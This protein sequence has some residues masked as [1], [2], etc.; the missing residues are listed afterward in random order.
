MKWKF[1]FL[2]SLFFLL[3]VWA[4]NA[5]LVASYFERDDLSIRDLFSYGL[6]V[7]PIYGFTHIAPSREQ[8]KNNS[9]QL[10]SRVANLVLERKPDSDLLAPLHEIARQKYFDNKLQSAQISYNHYLNAGNPHPKI[11]LSA[12]EK[13]QNEIGEDSRKANIICQAI[14]DELTSALRQS[15]KFVFVKPCSLELLTIESVSR[16]LLR[17]L[18]KLLLPFVEQGRQRFKENLQ[19]SANRESLSLQSSIWINPQTQFPDLQ[20]WCDLGWP[21]ICKWLKQRTYVLEFHFINTQY[22]SFLI[23]GEEK[24]FSTV[25]NDDTQRLLLEASN[26]PV[27]ITLDVQFERDNVAQIDSYRRSG[28]V[29]M[30][31]WP[32]IETMHEL[33]RNLQWSDEWTV[34]ISLTSSERLMQ[35]FKSLMS[36][37]PGF[38]TALTSFLNLLLLATLI[39]RRRFNQLSKVVAKQIQH[40]VD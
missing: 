39:L 19:F 30:F 15:D 24:T 26:Q 22:K 12:S 32:E 18:Q 23:N 38:V 36:N 6:V 35:M 25:D 10:P 4:F 14:H 40:D 8:T 3:N 16:Y 2:A 33:L 21:E 34:D 9:E 5:A 13:S 37:V 29:K 11:R 17:H 31:I 1:V 7:N 28:G 20:L 27:K